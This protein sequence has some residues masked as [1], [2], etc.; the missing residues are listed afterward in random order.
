MFIRTKDCFESLTHSTVEDLELP[1]IPESLSVKKQDLIVICKE[2]EAGTFARGD[3]KELVNLVLLYLGEGLE[4]FHGFTRPGALHKARWMSKLLYGIKIVLLRRRI[5]EL[6]KGSV[7]SSQQSE[8]LQ[9]F[10]LFTVFCYVPWWLTS[11]VVSACPLNDLNLIKTQQL[12]GDRQSSFLL[13]H[14]C[15][16]QPSVVSD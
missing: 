14:V 2:A 6:P 10:I 16:Q 8:K 13:C 11:P 1:I 7:F 5:S 3:Y 12:Q 9:R 4:S 15:L